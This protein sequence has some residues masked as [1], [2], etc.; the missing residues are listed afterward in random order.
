MLLG[1]HSLIMSKN[2]KVISEMLDTFNPN[3]FKI[4]KLYSL[5]IVGLLEKH[6]LATKKEVYFNLT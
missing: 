2:S 5:Q 3:A 6:Q 4:V 1:P